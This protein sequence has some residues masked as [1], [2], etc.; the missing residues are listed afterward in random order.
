[1]ESYEVLVETGFKFSARFSQLIGRNLISNPI[2]AVSELV[3]NSYDADADNI[4]LVFQNLKNGI[5]TLRIID[6]GE[7]MSLFDLTEKWMMVGTDN[8]MR[9]SIT[10]SGRRKLGE[11]GIGRFSV[12]RL[13]KKLTIRTTQRN[14]A[15][16]LI[17]TIN[18]D[19]YENSDGE[20]SDIKHKIIKVP[21]KEDSYGTELTLEYLRDIWDEN[22]LFDLRKELNLIRPIDINKVSYNK[23]KFKGDKV[24]IEILSDDFK[25]SSGKISLS[26]MEYAQAH[27]FGEIFEDGSGIIKLQ[28]KAN[29]SMSKEEIYEEFK[30]TAD[31]IDGSCGPLRYEVFVFFKD[32]RLYRSLNIDRT[33][34]ND[35]LESYSGIKIYRDGFRIL[36]FG[37]TDNDW[38]ELNARRTASPEHRIATTN[39]IGI[40]FIT[41]DENPGLQDVLS[42]ENMYD[43]FEYVA[44]KNFVNL[45]F[46]KYTNIQLTARKKKVKKQIEEGQVA[47]NDAEKSVK[48][49]VK[50]VE[51]LQQKL[52]E[53]KEEK[54]P[55]QQVEKIVSIGNELSALMNTAERSLNTVKFAY[56]YY[57]K[58]DSFKSREMQIYRNI[59][60]LGISAAMFGHEALH[61]TVD[62]KVICNQIKDDFEEL[63]R[64][65]S[66]LSPLFN[67][68]HKDIHLIDEK[69]DFFRNYLRR[70]KQDR[71][72]Y[73]NFYKSLSAI[74]KVHEKAFKAINAIVKVNNESD[75]NIYNTWGYEGDFDT[76]FTNL[77]TNA[78]KAIKKET[79]QKYLIFDMSYSSGNIILIASNNGKPIDLQTRSKIFEPLF[80]TY[81]DGTGLG[82]TIIQDT[83]TSYQGSI[84]LCIDY[85]ETK[86]K[87][88][89]PKKDEPKE[90]E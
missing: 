3:K 6:D 37:D 14:C 58:Q 88:V 26:F 36:P 48:T 31:E 5:S 80:S 73:I 66:R 25:T 2:V 44:L 16:A 22:T 67:D 28:I 32:Q 83:L 78:Y 27:L 29:I 1:M 39:A 60:T 30:Y 86:F 4:N 56:T 10:K 65:I 76:I 59:A 53:S 9:D 45:A 90:L 49:F 19:E 82:L 21:E 62:A 43:T 51:T 75:V 46:D 79:E 7:G 70:E 50:Q 54:N 81:S 8:K 41:R 89:L 17:V 13:A 87:L 47:L 72:R 63:A 38:L 57:K 64:D 40:V 12:E 24:N 33:K 55:Q 18:W 61:Q 69:A 20:F 68:L 35:L 11:K 52:S 77:I 71:A 85:P 15:Y 34:V 42:R 74:V 84:Q 23:Y